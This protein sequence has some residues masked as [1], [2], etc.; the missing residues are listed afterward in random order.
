[1][2]SRRHIRQLLVCINVV[3]A[4]SC[5]HADVEQLVEA[6]RLLLRGNYAESEV[7]FSKLAAAYP[8]QAAL[9]LSRCYWQQ[10][11]RNQAVEVIDELLTNSNPT[12]DLHAR[13]AWLALQ[14]GNWQVCRKQIESTRRLNPNHLLSSWAEA[15]LKRA[16]GNT[17]A[18]CQAYR[19]LAERYDREGAKLQSPRQLYWFGKA[20]AQHARYNHDQKRFP[21]LTT[22]LFP[23]ILTLDSN[24]WPAHYEI[25]QL[26]LEKFNAAD[27]QEA[28]NDALLINP[29]SADVEAGLA[30]LALHSFQFQQ[31][32]RHL[33]RAHKAN[34]NH[35]AA[36]LCRAD[37]HLAA[38]EPAK[39]IASLQKARKLNANDSITLGRLSAASG[40][41]NPTTITDHLLEKNEILHTA[42]KEGSIGEYY[43]AKGNALDYARRY[44]QAGANLSRAVDTMPQLLGPRSQLG[45]I[46]M[47]LGHEAKA[48]ELLKASFELDPYNV[49]V[50]NQLE[51]LDLLDTYETIETEHFV[52][53]FDGSKD[54]RLARHMARY[55]EQ[56]YA[57]LTET[58][59][60]QL[61]EKAI[62]EIFHDAQ[63][64]KARQWF[65]ARMVGLPNIHTIAAC[66]GNIVAM[67]SPTAERRK[68]NWADVL[69]HEMVHLINVQQTDYAVPHW[70]TEG[71]A[72]WQEGRPRRPHWNKLLVER[73]PK[74]NVFNLDSLNMGFL[75]PRTPADYQLAY[76]QADL[77][78]NLIAQR[79]GIAGVRKLLAAHRNNLPT[80]AAI[81]DSFDTSLEDLE[82]DYAQQLAETVAKLS[83]RSE[84]QPKDHL[85]NWSTSG[86]TTPMTGRPPQNWP[87]LDCVGAII[88]EQVDCRVRC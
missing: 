11:H 23:R 47:R 43:A 70:L 55:A 72:V 62:L 39:A 51:V 31:V 59:D 32:R 50:K 3:C 61:P 69:R 35:L 49:R 29:Q 75:R 80:A 12:A 13:R 71:C 2:T 66:G 36:H 64:I 79:Y 45:M 9:G 87:W 25:G 16:T 22:R 46:E 44:P 8:T 77:Y 82:R 18:A 14:N 74:G 6:D 41:V 56:C 10:G 38:L 34:P 85:P 26:L 21:E 42:L 48:R 52:I 4:V 20:L 19:Q 63:G 83:Q 53:R 68:I 84:F 78:I 54:Q 17:Q 60:Y 86:S 73:V 30:R 27:A 57:D 15:E 40:L 7:A 24:F 33:E 81:T 65:G 88:L 76:C 37:M 5:C 28:F 1:M 67:V 58:F